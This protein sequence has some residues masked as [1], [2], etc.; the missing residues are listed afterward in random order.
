MTKELR[1]LAGIQWGRFRAGRPSR[2]CR[3]NVPF[4]AEGWNLLVDQIKDAEG[5][6]GEAQNAPWLLLRMLSHR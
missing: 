1:I 4:D 3:V 2:G 6:G 5:L